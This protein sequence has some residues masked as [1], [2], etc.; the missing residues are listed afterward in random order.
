MGRGL[1]NAVDAYNKAIG[2]F[3]SRVLVTARKFT[4][5]GIAA[6]KEIP[7]LTPLEKAPRSIQTTDTDQE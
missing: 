1:D 4:E 7:L 3:E 2:S 6:N 5:F